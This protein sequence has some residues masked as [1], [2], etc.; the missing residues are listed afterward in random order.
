MTHTDDNSVRT[1]KMA[2]IVVNRCDDILERHLYRYWGGSYEYTHWLLCLL[3]RLS[4][5]LYCIQWYG[6][7]LENCW[8]SVLLFASVPHLKPSIEVH[9]MLGEMFACAAVSPTSVQT[10]VRAKCS[11]ARHFG[12]C[13]PTTGISRMEMVI[14]C[15]S[16]TASVYF[17][18]WG[19]QEWSWS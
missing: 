9:P 19:F 5:S 17:Q 3:H 15:V 1:V 16:K 18:L 14:T 12:S 13:T 2:V 7:H 11:G 4:V 6:K 8:C 10:A